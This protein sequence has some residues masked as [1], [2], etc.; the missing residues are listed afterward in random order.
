MML[1]T[2]RLVLSEMVRSVSSLFLVT[3]SA[4]VVGIDVKSDTTSK[5]TV[6]SCGSMVLEETFSTKSTT[7]SGAPMQHQLPSMA[8]QRYINLMFH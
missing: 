6:I 2:D 5:E 3:W 8:Y 4:R 7:H 1:F